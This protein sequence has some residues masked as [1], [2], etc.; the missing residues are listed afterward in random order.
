MFFGTP[1]PPP[2]FS[3]SLDEMVIT[4][5][6]LVFFNDNGDTNEQINLY[7]V[8]GSCKSNHCGSHDCNGHFCIDYSCGEHTCNTLSCE[9]YDDPEEH[10]DPG[11]CPNNC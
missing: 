2:E 1:P 3:Y 10:P 6:D 11:E 7:S 9:N 4:S 5:E 8:D